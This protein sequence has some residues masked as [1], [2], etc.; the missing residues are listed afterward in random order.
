MRKLHLQLS[1]LS[2]DERQ[3]SASSGPAAAKAR[4]SQ[5]ELAEKFEM[6]TN[7]S[8]ASSAGLSARRDPDALS[9]GLSDPADSAIFNV[10][11]FVF[12]KSIDLKSL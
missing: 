9:I 4:G 7:L 5:V 3:A 2:R 12:N 10:F 6:G 1:L 8:E 11:Y